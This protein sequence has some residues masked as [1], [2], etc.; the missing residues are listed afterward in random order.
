MSKA[1]FYFTPRQRQVLQALDAGY[2]T[3]ESLARRLG[4]TAAT[5]KRHLY[6]I[7]QAAGVRNTKALIVAARQNG[8]L[9]RTQPIRRRKRIVKVR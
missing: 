1:D 8:W 2:T 9:D 5:V 6:D 7:R 3:D 4:I